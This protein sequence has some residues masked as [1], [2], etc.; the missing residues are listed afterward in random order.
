[1]PVDFGSDSA[2][3]ALD[4]AGHDPRVPTT[5]VWEGVVMY[6]TAAR[7]ETTLTTLRRRSAP[8]SHLIVLY[9]SPAPILTLVGLATGWMGEP[10]RSTQTADAMRRMLADFGFS[11]NWDEDLPTLARPLDTDMAGGLRPVGHLRIVEAVATP[12]TRV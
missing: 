4:A 10:L 1:M 8:G 12:E 7:I 6:L 5:W 11:V 2:D 9:H 3:A